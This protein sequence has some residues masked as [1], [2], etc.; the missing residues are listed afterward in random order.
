MPIDGIVIKNIAFELKENILNSKIDKIYQPERDEIILNIRT[1]T[2]NLK[3]LL[4]CNPTYP[5]I[6]FT[7]ILK[8]NPSSAPMFCM[9]LRKHLLGGRIIDIIQ[10][11]LERI[12][13]IHVLS[14][15]NIGDF[16]VKR[17]II[18]IMGK[19]SNII[20][21]EENNK[22]IDCI[23]H[24]SEDIS[25]VREVL[26]G[27]SYISPP[28]DKINPC[29]IDFVSFEKLFNSDSKAD[30]IKKTLINSL[31]GFGNLIANEIYYR[32]ALNDIDEKTID[33]KILWMEFEKVISQLNDNRFTP[34]LYFEEDKPYDFSSINIFQYRDFQQ[35]VLSSISQ[36]IENFYY[37][38]DLKDRIRQ[39]TEEIRKTLKILIERC[40]RKIEKSEEKLIE[41]KD[42]EKY[43]IYGDLIFANLYGISKGQKELVTTNYYSQEQ[44][45]ITIPLDDT[46]SPNIIAQK[47]YKQYSKLKKAEEMSTLQL[48]NINNEVYYLE[49]V[50]TNLEN[51][52]NLDDINQIKIELE[53]QGYIK[54][55]NLKKKDNNSKP[56]S[57]VSSD[58]FTIFVGKNNIQN[59][60]LTLKNASN[61]DIWMHTKS[62]HGSH[63]VIKTENKTITDNTLY[64]AAVLASYYSKARESANVQVD[65]TLIKNVKKPS[66]AKPGMVI[67]VEYKTII[68]NPDINIVNKLKK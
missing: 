1:L 44:E 16:T 27:L 63:V 7:N 45:S 38:K 48:V 47:Y 59:D 32:Y 3:V 49:S 21:V 17:L 43:K 31:D 25:S 5:K 29:S 30:S 66:G 14:P 20:L 34:T 9:V 10:P 54:K 68:V 61:N 35:K 62:V 24:I 57:F 37:E 41:C 46:A 55:V 58:G 65:Y 51:C 67:Y 18:E 50:L 33:I 42:K 56:L 64:E 36:V 28:S 22:I 52:T 12:L 23:K 19:H 60:Q 53:M 2:S 39:K 8:D 15:N 11:S 13:E 6:H 26:P 40:Y 4:S